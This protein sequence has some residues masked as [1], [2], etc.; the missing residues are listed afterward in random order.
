VPT[1]S[2]RR[3]RPRPPAE[4]AWLVATALLAASLSG[5]GEPQVAADHR[6][7]VLRLATGTSTRDRG[8]LDRAAADVD[9][10]EAEGRLSDGEEKAF[11]AILDAAGAEEWDRAQELAYSLRDGQHP[12]AEDQERVAKRTVRKAKKP[13]PEP[14]DR[15][16]GPP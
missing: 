13:G 3:G 5:C 12:T 8:I 6:D 16:P 7:L 2:D 11:R 9:R 10:L 15:R 14:P 4:P 1:N